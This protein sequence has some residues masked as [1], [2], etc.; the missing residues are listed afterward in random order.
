LPRGAL[1]CVGGEALCRVFPC[2][3]DE[4]KT[5]WWSDC[6]R[7]P[8]SFS[9]RALASPKNAGI[10]SGGQRKSSGGGEKTLC[11]SDC[12]A[13]CL[14]SPGECEESGEPRFNTT[15]HALRGGTYFTLE[16]GM[17]AKTLFAKK[18]RG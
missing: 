16:V 13:F 11:W 2:L 3:R 17:L 14:F 10:E 4:P 5:L 18:K 7:C 6:A 8:A 15:D 12:A 9:L 1:G